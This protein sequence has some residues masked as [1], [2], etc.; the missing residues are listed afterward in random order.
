MEE[1]I[2]QLGRWYN[3]NIRLQD[4]ILYDFQYTATF[5][6]ETLE[7]VLDLLVLSAPIEYSVLSRKEGDD[8]TY[9]KKLVTIRLRKQKIRQ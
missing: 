1:V 2:K 5:E 3:V 9:S 7:Q 4:T 6:N 8:C